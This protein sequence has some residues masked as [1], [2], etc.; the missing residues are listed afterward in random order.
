MASIKMV[1]LHALGEGAIE[2]EI[3]GSGFGGFV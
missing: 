2:S 1:N 3:A